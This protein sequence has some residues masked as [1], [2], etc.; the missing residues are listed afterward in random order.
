MKIPNSGLKVFQSG[1][2]GRVYEMLDRSLWSQGYLWALMLFFIQSIAKRKIRVEKMELE[3][4]MSDIAIGY[5]GYLCS[6]LFA[7]RKK[8]MVTGRREGSFELSMNS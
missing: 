6:D 7:N 3:L 4:I 2:A 5:L 8:I 1:S